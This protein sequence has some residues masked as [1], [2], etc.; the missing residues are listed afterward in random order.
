MNNLKNHLN[1]SLNIGKIN[2]TDEDFRRGIAYLMIVR[3]LSVNFSWLGVN[4]VDQIDMKV[5]GSMIDSG[6]AMHGISAW[7][8]LTHDGFRYG[9]ELL[10]E[11][12]WTIQGMTDQQVVSQLD[13]IVFYVQKNVE[14]TKDDIENA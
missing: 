2:D 10:G 7:I 13:D 12:Y 5:V 3:C 4:L 6:I 1:S 14:F 9:K 11:T 8:I